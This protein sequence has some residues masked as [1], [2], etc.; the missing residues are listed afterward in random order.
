MTRK[1]L[2][3][4][5]REGD[6]ETLSR[7]WDEAKAA[8]DYG[9]PIPAGEYVCHLV[10]ANLFNAKTKGTPGVKLAFKVIEG[11]H[12]G[13][14]VWHDC[15]LTGLALP[16]TKRDLLKLGIERL[17]QLDSPLPPG[18]RCAVRVAFRQDDH[19]NPFNRV[20]TF[21]VV[22]I[23]PPEQ[24]AFAPLDAP[25]PAPQPEAADASA[26]GSNDRS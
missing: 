9:E 7:A 23:D 20:K 13:R 5:L 8:D 14:R 1:S 3:D 16:Q 18:I 15:W 4:I 21:T 12:T 25:G 10:A 6:R 26:G 17:E 24:D 11:E 19:G 22:D 2:S